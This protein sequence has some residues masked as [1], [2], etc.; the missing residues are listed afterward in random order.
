[1]KLY[2]RTGDDGSTGLYG[3]QRTT[4][5]ALRVEAYGTVD[6]FNSAL[7]M[8]GAACDDDELSA[9]IHRVQSRLFDL[10]ADLCT[11]LDATK[12]RHQV[13]ITPA[14][15]TELEG[16]IDAVTAKLPPLRTF[17]LP[18]GCE[19]AA[20]L[21]VART[22]A[23]RAERRIVALAHAEPV[24]EGVVPYVNRLSDLLFAMGRRANQLAG[25]DDVPWIADADSSGD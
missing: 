25:V 7:G 10:G 14:H 12:V 2:T 6:E 23:R 22:I 3:G 8:A 9:I 21:H 15:V 13:R 16:L 18:G 17:I 4:K 11:P 5:D 1:V 19:L 20:R 24:G